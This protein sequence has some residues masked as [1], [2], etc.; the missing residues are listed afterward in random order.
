MSSPELTHLQ[1]PPL[2]HGSIEPK[3]IRV[4]YERDGLCASLVSPESLKRSGALSCE[5]AETRNLRFMSPEEIRNRG[6]KSCAS[7]VWGL[8]CTL[9][10]L[11]TDRLPF[12]EQDVSD[13]LAGRAAFETLKLPSTL[14]PLVESS[15]D[16]IVK[17]AL[18][19]TV[20]RRYSDA[21]ELLID[22]E[23][24]APAT[25]VDASFSDVE[26]FRDWGDLPRLYRA[27]TWRQV[28]EICQ[29]LKRRRFS[30]IVAA[31]ETP[32]LVAFTNSEM[33]EL[34]EDEHNRWCRERAAEKWTYGI[35]KDLAARKSPD[36]VPW[37]ALSEEARGYG[38][39]VCRGWPRQ[40]ANGGY[41]IHRL[42]THSELRL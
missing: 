11:L 39:V 30:V 24:I 33:E 18:S 35:K 4:G 40:F 10:L 2:I 42:Q 19:P 26:R 16:A 41:E 9:Y 1:V 29:I 14:N 7:D 21:R 17:R 20:E 36:L 8:G 31:S 22:L 5:E 32:Q 3:N 23:R 12:E 13:L 37:D 15:L 27:G 34:A 25:D 6:S 38:R 28:S